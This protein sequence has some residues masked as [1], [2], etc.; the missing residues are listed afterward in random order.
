MMM[1]TDFNPFCCLKQF[2]CNKNVKS[3]LHACKTVFNLKDRD[4]FESSDLVESSAFGKVCQ[5][6]GVVVYELEDH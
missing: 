3:F 2:L 4:L 6:A 1:L 5:F